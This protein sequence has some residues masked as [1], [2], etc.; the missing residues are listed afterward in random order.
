MD[1]RAARNFTLLNLLPLGLDPEWDSNT[2]IRTALGNLTGMAFQIGIAD[3]DVVITS[4]RPVVI[5]PPKEGQP[6]NRP[7]AV[8]FPLTSKLLLYLYPD[9]D[10]DP[11]ARKCFVALN[12]EQINDFYR[13]S[14]VYA[15]DWIYSRNPLTEEQIRIVSDARRDLNT[16]KRSGESTAKRITAGSSRT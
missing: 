11:I 16:G 9:E 15:R 4:D 12:K 5:W 1:T 8:T 7:R 10:V 14:S 2:I 13:N 3:E 6:Y